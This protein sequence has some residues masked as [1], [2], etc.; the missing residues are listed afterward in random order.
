MTEE[1]QLGSLYTMRERIGGGATGIVHA[2]TDRDG[3]DLAFKV[4]RE[5]LAEQRSVVTAFLA[6]SSTLGSID[7]PHVVRVR[8][9]VGERGTLAV[10]MERVHGGDLRA[11]LR[12]RGTFA[13]AEVATLGAQIAEGLAAVHRAGIVH[14]DVKPENVLLD[15]ADDA[16]CAKVTDFGIAQLAESAQATRTSMM[17]GTVNYVAPEI[18]AGQPATPKADLYSLGILLYELTCGVTPFEGGNSLAV[19]RRHTEQHPGRPQGFPQPLMR[20]ILPLLTKEPTRR[21]TAQQV[22]D[23]LRTLPEKLADAQAMTPLTEPVPGPPVQSTAPRRPAAQE[24]RV[25]GA[26]AATQRVPGPGTVGARRTGP[27]ATSGEPGGT[28]RN[29]RAGQLL[30]PGG[31]TQNPRHT[32]NPGRTP[33]PTGHPGHGQPHGAAAMGTQVGQAGQS[34]VASLSSRLRERSGC[35]IAAGIGLALL[36]MAVL[37]VGLVLGNDDGDSS[38][39]PSAVVIAPVTALEPHAPAEDGR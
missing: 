4:L 2:G 38:G 6:E 15:T 25:L 24:T 12:Q 34:G 31:H 17:R 37:A 14:R 3:N 35:L 28:P 10:V 33:Q 39:E 7:S 11:A 32:P 22:A 26:G 5:E 21:P 30:H 18:L 20:A 9:V 19:I 23:H 13:P 8:D 1:R 16:P 29:V 27:G 36:L